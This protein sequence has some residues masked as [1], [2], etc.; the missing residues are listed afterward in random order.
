VYVT[1]TTDIVGPAEE[2]GAELTGD[3]GVG[4]KEGPVPVTVTVFVHLLARLL[5]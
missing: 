3:D 2:T 4:A 1:K 5:C